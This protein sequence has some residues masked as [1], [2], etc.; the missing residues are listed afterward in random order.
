[1]NTNLTG[2]AYLQYVPWLTEQLAKLQ[3]LVLEG[4][5]VV[6]GSIGR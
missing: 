3:G 4:K 1:M 2:E 5:L 6:A